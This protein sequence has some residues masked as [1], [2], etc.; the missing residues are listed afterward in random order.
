MKKRKT[1]IKKPAAN[2]GDAE[3][4]CADDGAADAGATANDGDT[5]KDSDDDK[6]DDEAADAGATAADDDK[7]TAGEEK[8]ANAKPKPKA[9]PRAA[10]RPAAD[11]ANVLKATGAKATDAAT[12]DLPRY[13]KIVYATR[14]QIGIRRAFGD[15][16]QIGSVPRPDLCLL[17]LLL[18]LLPLV[19]GS[20]VNDTDAH[21]IDMAKPVNTMG[22]HV[23]DTGAHMYVDMYIYLHTCIYIYMYLCI[24]THID[25]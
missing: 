8:S 5:E 11:D 21:V 16:K 6:A 17:L 20:H 24:C 14:G 9:K 18:L 7:V 1:V 15:K 3:D 23:N 13:L 12:G 19:L 22:T 4:E 10:K 25:L 2:D